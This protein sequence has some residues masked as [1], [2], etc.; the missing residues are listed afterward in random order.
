M[1]GWEDLLGN[2]LATRAKQDAQQVALDAIAVSADSAATDADAIRIAAESIDSKTPALIGGESPVLDAQLRTRIGNTT[3]AEAS[4]GDG[5]VVGILKAAR[6]L[7]T[8]IKN[9]IT[10]TL[11]IGGTVALDAPTQAALSPRPAN[12]AARTDEFLNA[13]R[14]E[15]PALGVDSVT[16]SIPHPD[17]PITIDPLTVV[18]AGGKTAEGF[19]VPMRTD[20]QGGQLLSDAPVM[21]TG[22]VFGLGAPLLFSV[23]TTGYQSVSVQ[24]IGAWAGT[25]TFFVSNNGSDWITVAGYAVGSGAAMV[26][27]A[28]GNGMFTFPT[29]GR[30]FKA[31]LTAYTSGAPAA[32][33]FLRSQPMPVLASTSSMNAAQWGGTA[34]ANGGVAGVPAVGGNVAAGVA[35]TANPINVGGWDGRYTRRF[36]TDTFGSLATYEVAPPF[37][38]SQERPYESQAQMLRELRILNRL[39][40]ELPT[41]LAMNGRMDDMDAQ[42]RADDTFLTRKQR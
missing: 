40:C 3:D 10:S 7:L 8:A 24:I 29:A 19:T 17:Y 39:I 18:Q 5:S 33:A 32:I 38:N 31:Q 23:N 16:V 9:A 42:L 14:T 6:S 1:A 30:Y 2:E 27:S 28:A 34:V 35:P 22:Q 41:V 25:I 12:D 37:T 21:V 4:S 11:T 36:L 20:A 13:L 26:T 15:D